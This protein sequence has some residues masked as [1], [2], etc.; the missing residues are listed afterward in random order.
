MRSDNLKE[1]VATASELKEMIQTASADAKAGKLQVGAVVRLI[2]LVIVW[3][4]QLAAT[5]GTYSVPNISPQAI[6]LISTVITI[7]VSLYGYWKN[8]SWTNGAKVADIVL[9]VIKD[10]GISTDEVVGAIGTLVDSHYNKEDADMSSGDVS[11]ETMDAQDVYETDN[12]PDEPDPDDES[13]G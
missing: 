5:F 8:N 12:E 7:V 13:V 10:S 4:N 3:V 9:D 11:P 6:Y 2:A 1:T